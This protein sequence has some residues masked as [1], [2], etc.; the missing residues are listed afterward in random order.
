MLNGMLDF[1]DENGIPGFVGGGVG[2]ARVKVAIIANTF[3]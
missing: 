1:G 2:V 3:G